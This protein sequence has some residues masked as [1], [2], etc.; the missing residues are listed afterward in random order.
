MQVA[1]VLQGLDSKQ[2]YARLSYTRP[3]C[4]TCSE[5]LQADGCCETP[6]STVIV[7]ITGTPPTKMLYSHF[8][9]VSRK[10]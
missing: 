4:R 8:A 1:K 5:V 3:F 10:P 9:G 6:A 7:M 2:M